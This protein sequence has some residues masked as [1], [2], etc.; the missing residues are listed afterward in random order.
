MNK[1]L[2]TIHQPETYPWLGFFNKMMLADEYVILD[3]VQFRKNYFQNRNQFLTKQGAIYL[4]VPIDFKSNKIIKNIKIRYN[5]KWQLKHL[6]TIK[7][8]YS[9]STYFHVHIAFFEDLYSKKFELLIE[10]NMYIINYL[11]KIFD[12]HTPVY[13]ASKLNVEGVSGELLLN[14]C[15]KL[16]ATTYLSGRDGR[17]YLDTSIFEKENI[18]IMY[19]EF[20][21][22]QYEQ[23]NSKE[24][25]PYINTFDLLLNYSIKQ[26]KELIL[27]GGT[28]C[29]K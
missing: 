25:M 12:I 13:K 24:F 14:I 23:F 27:S 22:P 19:H 21:H 2:I 9:K 15:K 18:T 16:G 1:K 5:E 8:A 20:M 6:N 3:N 17:N 26:S 7:Q 28:F 10:F 4:S 11:R 29:E